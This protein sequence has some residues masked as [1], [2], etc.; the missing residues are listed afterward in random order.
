MGW[1]TEKTSGE[2]DGEEERGVYKKKEGGGERGRGDGGEKGFG[3]EARG[4][5]L[6]ILLLTPP[7]AALTQV[8]H[9][10][11]RRLTCRSLFRPASAGKEALDNAPLNLFQSTF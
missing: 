10:G 5:T 8:P 7:N 9:V 4:V 1:E 11:Y 2:G 3:A 6:G